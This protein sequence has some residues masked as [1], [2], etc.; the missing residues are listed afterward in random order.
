MKRFVFILFIFSL[1][2]CKE[3]KKEN[4]SHLVK[5]WNN[6]KI[7]YPDIMHFTVLGADTNFLFKSE[8]RI[9][10]YVD[11]AGCTS[12][13][14]KLEWWKKFISQLDT[15]GNL[16]VLFFLHPKNRKELNYILKRDNFNYPVCIDENDSLN[17]L[18]HFPSDLMFQTFLLDKDNRVLAIGNPIHNP[19]VKELYLKIIQGE[20]VEKDKGTEVINTKP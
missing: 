20:K 15:I 5:E 2:S 1:F 8:Y 4:I 6:K 19:K 16:P 10:T 18:N 3:T 9:I 14:L 12:C 7:V 13:K 11:S 17:K